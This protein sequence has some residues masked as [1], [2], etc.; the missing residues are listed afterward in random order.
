ML[1]CAILADRSNDLLAEALGTD[2][3]GKTSPVFYLAAIPLAYVN[4]WIALGLYGAV[5]AIWLIPDRRIERT[6]G[7]GERDDGH[8]R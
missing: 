4:A 6:L 8:D 3:K 2:W 7:V 1:Q 5:A